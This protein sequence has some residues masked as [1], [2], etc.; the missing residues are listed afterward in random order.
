MKS[1]EGGA[2]DSK[3]DGDSGKNSEGKEKSPQAKEKSASD[4]K[5]PK[6]KDVEDASQAQE[7]AA[8]QLE[9]AKPADA[10][11]KQEEAL[12]QLEKAQQELKDTLEQLRKEQQEE[13]LAALEARFRT[14][15][16]KQVEVSKATQH[17][18]ELG[19]E[20][21]KRS[22]QL[23]LGE[24]SPKQREIGDEADKTLYILTEEG[25]TV[26]FPQIVRQIRDDARD[27][28]TR[29]AAADA[30]A[31]VRGIQ[32][33]IEQAL[34]ELIDAVKKKQEE[35]QSGKESGGEGQNSPQPLLP[36][37]AELKLLRSCQARVNMATKAL[38]V[39]SAKPSA[40]ADEFQERIRKL[41]ARQ[42]EISKMAKEMHE[43]MTKAQ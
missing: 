24:L 8:K 5:G 25:T 4:E 42:E 9:A 31:E 11:K 16:A 3:Q 33:G 12:K 29:L 23:E 40:K 14:M 21:W 20:Q 27:T 1:S 43:A 2:P 34:R 35:N 38:R 30:G 19:K 17:L 28:A 10:V 18:T 22:D 37:S 39:D 13:M 41:A 26:A 6:P 7:E 32:T 36:G 15:L